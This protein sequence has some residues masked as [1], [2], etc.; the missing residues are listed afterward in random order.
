MTGR[1]FQ[2]VPVLDEGDAIGNHARRMARILGEQHGGFLVERA[3][4]ALRGLTI[5]WS[6]ARIQPDDILV[7]HVALASQLGEWLRQATARKVIDYHGIT[8]PIF[9]LAYDPG[10]SVALSRA[11]HELEGLRDQV[12][13]AL[14]DSDYSRAEL[15]A[16]GFSR[17]ETLPILLDLAE[18]EVPGNQQLM[19][20]LARGKRERGDLLFVGR[21]APNK[22]QEDLIKAFTVYRRAYHPEARLFLVGR[23]EIEA[24]SAVLGSL[25]ERL[26]IEG[27]HFAGQ[28]SHADLVA[29]YRSADAFVS[30]SE[31]EGYGVPWL[32][33]MY[34]GLPV[35]TFGAGAIAET[36]GHGG[37]VFRRK[38][39][40]EVA[41]LVN[42]VVRDE[43]V[44]AALVEAGRA[45]I[46]QLRPE[47]FEDRL[48]QLI[49][50]VG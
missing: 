25:V 32:E 9:F 8:P 17:T 31:H 33:A 21:I 49:D 35:V 43:A 13:L 20:E 11:R 2:L 39:Y 12:G 36:V 23:P 10:L 3:A 26:G 14:A 47:K 22:R 16:M 38:R 44:R 37:I 34:F 19:E 1:V 48:R 30:M 42:L 5:P 29:Y 28:V 40:E 41:A 27:V 18:Y 15:D 24:Y 4:P 7:Y 46:N 45:R 6:D 50:D